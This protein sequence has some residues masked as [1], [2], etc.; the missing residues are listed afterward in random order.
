[1]Q[2]IYNCDDYYLKIKG[3]NTR[4][5]NIVH[6]MCQMCL[7]KLCHTQNFLYISQEFVL[8]GERTCVFFALLAAAI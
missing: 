4:I 2:L 7:L 1:M 5:V 8:R 3:T 6:V